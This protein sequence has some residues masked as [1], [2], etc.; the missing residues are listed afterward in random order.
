MAQR[1]RQAVLW[2]A[3]GHGGTQAL[4]LLSNLVR[5]RL[6]F[7]E[8]FGL[9]AIVTAVM[10]GLLLF[11]DLGVGLSVIQNERGEESD[12]LDTAWTAQVA[13]GAGLSTVVLLLA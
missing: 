6:L 7:P 12:F 11:S 9:M 10:T 5:T 8:V 13:R 2:V 1:V 4:R 3:I